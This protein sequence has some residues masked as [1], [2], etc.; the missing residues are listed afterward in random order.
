MS[1]QTDY[2]AI[3]LSLLFLEYSVD[4]GCHSIKNKVKTNIVLKTNDF[5]PLRIPIF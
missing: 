4:L 5:N 2:I 3:N 1:V